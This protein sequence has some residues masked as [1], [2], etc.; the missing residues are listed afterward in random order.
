MKKTEVMTRAWEIKRTTDKDFS[1]SL[2]TAWKEYR[3]E[4]I[5]NIWEKYGK[6]RAYFNFESLIGLNLNYYGTGNIS[7]ASLNGEKISN[8]EARRLVSKYNYSKCFYD[9]KTLK[10]V[11]TEN[12]GLKELAESA[13]K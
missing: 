8:S 7:S 4:K 2:K 13:I 1:E 3:I 10:I 9:Y 11:E 5:A 6:K 12:T